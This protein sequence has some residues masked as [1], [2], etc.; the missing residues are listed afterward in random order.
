VEDTFVWPHG[1]DKLNDFLNHLN[2]THQCIQFTMQTGREGHLPFLKTDIYRDTPD[3]SLGHRLYHKPTSA[4]GP[5]TF[6]P[7]KKLCFP[8]WSIGLVFSAMETACMRSWCSLGTVTKT[9]RFTVSSTV[10]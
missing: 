4:L 10:L 7:T 1:P 5:I 8:H 6:Y 3:S 2:S 9:G